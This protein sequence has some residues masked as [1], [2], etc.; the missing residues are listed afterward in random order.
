MTN[1]NIIFEEGTRFWIEAVNFNRTSLAAATT[2]ND[3]HVLERS[4]TFLGIAG[5]IDG[6]LGVGDMADIGIH[7]RNQTTGAALL[8]GDKITGVTIKRTNN[9]VGAISFGYHL[10]IYMRGSGS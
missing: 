8:H 10:L 6:N 2:A 4:G 9:A 3:A 5:M 1:T 7:C